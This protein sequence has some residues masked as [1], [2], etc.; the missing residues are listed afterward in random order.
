[1]K[2]GATTSPAAS[3]VRVAWPMRLRTVKGV[4]FTE[5][6]DMIEER[7]TPEVTDRMITA[8]AVPSGGAYTALRTPLNAIIGYSEM[9][10]EETSDQ[11][12]SAMLPDLEKIHTAGKHL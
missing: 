1:M 8:A 5:F 2:P 3:M 10:L 9:L 4:V 7:F 6:L 11:G 12:Q